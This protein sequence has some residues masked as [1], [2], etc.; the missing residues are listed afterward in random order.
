MRHQ[1]LD[2]LSPASEGP[3]AEPAPGGV[4]GASHAVAPGTV[5]AALDLGTNNC[6]M[7]IA[8]ADAQDGFRLLEAFSRITRLGEGLGASGAL[9]EEAMARTVTALR[10]CAERAQ[11][12]Q[13]THLRAVTTEACRRA[14]NAQAFLER[15]QRQTGIALD[16]VPPEEEARLAVAGCV[17][18]LDGFAGHALVFDIGGGSTEVIWVKLDQ[19][20]HAVLDV[21]SVP[22][23]VVTIAEASPGL[24]I[25]PQVRAMVH[26]RLGTALSAFDAKHGIAAKA[27]RGGVRMLGTSGTVTTL[28]ALH[29]GLS[30]YDRS[31][32][33]G[34][35]LAMDDLEA[36]RRD[37][38]AMSHAARVGHGCIGAR[39]AD[40]V[41]AGCA[42]LEAI[43]ATWPLG[44]ITIADRGV[45]E[46]II[47]GLLAGDT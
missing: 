2:D 28:A 14:S 33:D 20:G 34:L 16:V 43:C 29:L 25:S 41:M 46:G 22:L 4:V 32:I 11:R 8:E 3:A 45:R 21:L 44:A 13:V 12:R 37:L 1:P 38:D 23:G 7:M 24:D 35:T 17:S 31:R 6:R 39:R 26:E 9:Q 40:L 5:L 27:Q 10:R 42:V 36:V 47:M 15:V 30:K 19:S 18:L